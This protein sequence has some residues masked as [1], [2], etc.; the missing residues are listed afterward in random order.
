MRIYNM[1]IAI[2]EDRVREL[3]ADAR[4]AH[5]AP[6]ARAHCASRIRRALK[7]R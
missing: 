7:S 5:T 3:R 4:R 1:D 6:S 2:M